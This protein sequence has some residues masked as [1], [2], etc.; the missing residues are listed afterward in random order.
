M[1][2]VR[3][4]PALTSNRYNK[5]VGAEELAVSSP[6][7]C[8]GYCEVRRAADGVAA[9]SA[10]A[11]KA[12]AQAVGDNTSSPRRGRVAIRRG[13]AADRVHG[14]SRADAF[15]PVGDASLHRP[16]STSTSAPSC[17]SARDTPQALSPAPRRRAQ[18]RRSRSRT[19]QSWRRWGR[20]TR[21]CGPGGGG[22][23]REQKG[24]SGRRR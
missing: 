4:L 13:A 21:R 20:A 2:A 18:R 17:A 10:P 22:V 7:T 8:R 6:S 14:T 19:R 23:P 3:G 15:L 24:D 16:V 5:P 12:V 1:R 11:C 9:R